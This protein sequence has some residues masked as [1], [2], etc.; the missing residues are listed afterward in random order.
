MLPGFIIPEGGLP[1]LKIGDWVAITINGHRY[2]S[3]SCC[4]GT[5]SF[6]NIGDTHTAPYIRL[7]PLLLLALWQSTLRILSGIR[8]AVCM[9]V[10]FTFVMSTMTFCGRPLSYSSSLPIG[11]RN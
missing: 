1:D 3:Y 5:H 8:M 4:E 6:L 2:A 11:V 7:A 10:V 9:A